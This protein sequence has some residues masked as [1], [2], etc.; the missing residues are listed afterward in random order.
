[1]HMKFQISFLIFNYQISHVSSQRL[2]A[3]YIPMNIYILCIAI[4]LPIW[5]DSFYNLK[6]IIN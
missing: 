2:L 1:M 5:S 3:C 4:C 6:V